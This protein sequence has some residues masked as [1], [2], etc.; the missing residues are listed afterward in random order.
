MLLLY[1]IVHS[2]VLIQSC[3][4]TDKSI[5][6][7]CNTILMCCF[8]FAITFTLLL[9]CH[10]LCYLYKLFY[11]QCT[12]YSSG[13]ISAVLQVVFPPV[14]IKRRWCWGQAKCLYCQCCAVILHWYPQ[15]C[16]RWYTQCPNNTLPSHPFLSSIFHYCHPFQLPDFWSV[17]P[18]WD[19]Y[20]VVQYKP[21]R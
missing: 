13:V 14:N 20:S 19:T 2:A 9:I 10:A 17:P 4:I 1:I 3:A 21:F 5:T 8:S 11:V 15:A 6:L 16:L 12:I 7:S 18:V